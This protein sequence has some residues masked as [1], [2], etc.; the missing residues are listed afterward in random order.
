MKSIEELPERIRKKIRV[1]DDTGCWRWIAAID[2]H[3]YGLIQIKNRVWRSHRAVYEAAVGPIAAG[4]CCDHLCRNRWCCNP[5]HIELVT[6]VENTMR[7]NAPP[8]VW[9]RT[10]Y[11]PTCGSKMESGK[12]KKRL[13]RSCYRKTKARYFRTRYQSDPE[14]RSKSQM[15]TRQWR[16]KN[17]GTADD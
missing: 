14:F 5:K 9:A 1:D 17:K 16:E 7:G 13:C 10:E 6:R 3:G 11:C 2:R 15:Y 4:L 12:T 8:A